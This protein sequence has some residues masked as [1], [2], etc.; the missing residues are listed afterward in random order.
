MIR[1]ICASV[2]FRRFFWVMGVV[3]AA[4]TPQAASART[5]TVNAVSSSFI[6]AVG[7]DAGNTGTCTLGNAILALNSD[8]DAS[9]TILFDA[10]VFSRPQTIAIG[11][12]AP[13]APRYNV[14]IVGPGANLLTLQG[15]SSQPVFR[16]QASQGAGGSGNPLVV[17]LSGMSVTGGLQGINNAG[18]LTVDACVIAG[19]ANGSTSNGGGIFNGG[20]L[21]LTNS[22]VSG[23]SAT[24][25]GFGYGGGIFNDSTATSL[26]IANSTIANNTARW[27][28]GLDNRSQGSIV[29][30]N[31][32][33]SANQVTNGF[34]GGFYNESSYFPPGSAAMVENSIISGNS[35]LANSYADFLGAAPFTIANGLAVNTAPAPAMMAIA[36]RSLGNYGGTTPT[37]P[38]QAG[39]PAIGAGVF[40]AGAP[41]L[42]QI[43]AP[44]PSAAG[45][46]IDAGAVQSTVYALSFASPAPFP[47]AVVPG[48]AFAVAVQ[49]MNGAA[50]VAGVVPALSASTAAGLS[51]TSSCQPSDAG[52]LASCSIT[53]T[54][55]SAGPVSGVTLTAA[56]GAGQAVSQPFKVA[57][58]TA[59]AFRVGAPAQ[60][61]VGQPFTVTVTAV[62]DVGNAVPSYGGTVHFASGDAGATLPTN[63]ILVGGSGSFS[64]RLYAVGSH[65]V[66]ATD[67]ADGSVTGTT[68]TQVSL[69][70][71]TVANVSPGDGPPSGGTLVSITGT[72]FD[73]S[74][75][76]FFGVVSAVPQSVTPTLITVASPAG[77]PGSTVPVQVYTEG[78]FLVP[79]QMNCVSATTVASAFAYDGLV[80]TTLSLSATPG[81]V[82]RNQPLTLSATLNTNGGA[83]ARSLAKAAALPG[84]TVTFFDNG[85]SLGAATLDASGSASLTISTL[86]VGAH[87]ITANYSGDGNYA[88]AAAGPVTVTIEAQAPVT[89]MPVP[90]LS[91]WGQALLA[92]LV[93]AAALASRRWTNPGAFAKSRMD[94]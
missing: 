83:A 59:V 84:G 5:Y 53:F 81:Q 94:H 36:L 61:G 14:N 37:M 51:S 93:A 52:G 45:A 47:A 80:S 71:P 22:T 3:V 91:Y 16:I 62:D 30:R 65:S 32:T 68:S 89:P 55:A 21:T 39:S 66:T 69:L 1:R 76:V 23:N 4:S 78:C 64:L 54:L 44:R 60:V 20:S 40:A 82:A 57:A 13:L 77:A 11:M 75:K 73:A 49:V 38:P 88:S 25:A 9:A 43:G 34:G 50:P 67:V 41:A 12:A 85:G 18:T 63:A 72:N 19:N 90:M 58:Q 6:N 48:S 46:I 74:A 42:D 2:A 31:T 15:R 8:A 35:A 86:A 70:P 33:I 24:N 87:A 56:L 79:P 29:I 26:L 92:A 7:C 10:T 17:G 27:G 28:G